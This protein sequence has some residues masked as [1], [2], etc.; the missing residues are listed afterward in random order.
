MGERSLRAHGT[1][2]R[3]VLVLAAAGLLSGCGAAAHAGRSSA[4]RATTYVTC[5]TPA[6]GCMSSSQMKAKP[7]T[8]YL[9]GDGSLFAKGIAWRGWGTRTAIGTG[10]AWADDCKPNC[11]QGTFRKHPA[12]IVLTDPKPWHRK[13][14]YS[15][16]LDSVPAI[17]WRFTF[18]R[19]LM[20]GSAPPAAATA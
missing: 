13:M 11:A 15:R 14:A 10:T 9:S 16:Q 20:P 3:G 2:A 7:T 8:M 6:D 18:A 1:L 17:G 12:T 19:G 4:P 5:T